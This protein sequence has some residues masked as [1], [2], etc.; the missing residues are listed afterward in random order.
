MLSTTSGRTLRFFGSSS[1][2]VLTVQLATQVFDD[3]A[4]FKPPDP[5]P[6]FSVVEKGINDPSSMVVTRVSRPS[7]EMLSTLIAHYV[8]TMNTLYPFIDESLIPSDL[9]TYL[10]DQQHEPAMKGRLFGKS[11][12]QF[13]RIAMMCAVACANK[14][15]HKPHLVAV[16]DD[17]Y[18][19]GLKYVEAVTSEVSG[20]SLQALLLLILYC[21]FHP[22]K[23]DIWKLLDYA[24]RL[25]VELG[26]HT[27]L[28]LDQE[29][30]R[31]I[32]LRRSTF[33][34]LYTIERI[35]GQIF[36]RPSDL[37]EQ[38]ITTD[39]PGILAAGSPTDQASVQVFSAAH[40]YRLVYLRSEIYREIYLP[41]NP[42][43]HDLEWR[44][45]F[46]M[47]RG[48]SFHDRLSI[49]A[50]PLASFVSIFGPTRCAAHGFRKL[51]LCL[52]THSDLSEHNQGSRRHGAGIYP[53][54]IMSAHYIYLA[55]MTIMA[56]AQ[57]SIEG[58][59]QILSPLTQ[60]SLERI[61][62]AIDYSD[63]WK[64]SSA[65]LALLT[66]CT[67]TWEGMR[68]MQD[69]YRKMSEKLLPELARRGM[70]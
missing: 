37:P 55:G 12:Y 41:T 51:S 35:V 49:P 69:M 68:G 70:A 4:L 43:H 56:Y 48:V 15:R 62:Q 16:D 23:G 40:H 5:F 66:W 60:G 58:R 3:A 52:P 42:P 13:F 26:Y 29:S 8:S 11:A 57:L 28:P 53:M 59:V 17:F 67:T 14:S 54:T 31:D 63:I 46:D 50:S 38:I 44:W 9:G 25:S 24:C 30:S 36:G 7:K 61:T 20:E 39:Y 19:K 33:W 1:V 22:R 21:L 32:A 45:D 2:F 6:P 27:E 64:I 65:C 34:S 47:Q 10:S 18:A